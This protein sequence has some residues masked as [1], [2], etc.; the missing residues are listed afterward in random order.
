MLLNASSNKKHIVYGGNLNGFQD[1][2]LLLS[3]QGRMPGHARGEFPIG[4]TDCI[5]S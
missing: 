2:K 3:E 1:I 4:V 5:L